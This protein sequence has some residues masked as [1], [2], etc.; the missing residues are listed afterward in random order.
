MVF[1]SVLFRKEYAGDQLFIFYFLKCLFH[2]WYNNPFKN[3]EKSYHHFIQDK[4]FILWLWH[5]DSIFQIFDPEIS[6]HLDCLSPVISRF[7]M[8]HVAFVS[9]LF[10]HAKRRNSHTTWKKIRKKMFERFDVLCKYRSCSLKHLLLNISSMHCL[11]AVFRRTDTEKP[12]WLFSLCAYSLSEVLDQHLDKMMLEP[13]CLASGQCPEKINLCM[14]AL[15]RW[16]NKENGENLICPL[17]LRGT[18]WSWVPRSSSDT[19]ATTNT[20]NQQR[21]TNAHLKR[22][23]DWCAAVSWITG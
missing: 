9:N 18:L 14:T 13:C 19:Y 2:K 22:F 1:R 3:E 5:S 21:V 7:L 23:S 12:T 10:C 20:M 6:L 15:D 4:H 16:S 8:T 17:T 11:Q